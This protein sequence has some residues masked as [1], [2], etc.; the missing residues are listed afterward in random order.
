LNEN[1]FIESWVNKI[2]KDGIKKF[3]QDFIDQSLLEL[4][5]IPVKTL[6]MGR[7]FFGFYEIIT[8][9]GEQVFQAANIDEARFFI[10]SAKERNGKASLPLDRSMARPVVDAYNLILDD[11]IEQIKKDYRI[12]FPEGKNFLSV[13]NEIF[14]KLN[15]IRY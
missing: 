1:L 10:Y 14:Q 3:P 4:F 7:E 13:S 6:V 9:N 15:L 12:N 8:T 5:T 2:L 11:L